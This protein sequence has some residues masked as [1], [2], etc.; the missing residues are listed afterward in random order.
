MDIRGYISKQESIIQL[1][2][3]TIDALFLELLQHVEIEEI[4]N[5]KAFRMIKEVAERS[6]S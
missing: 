2:S 1:Q 3:E 5:S 6:K 4:E